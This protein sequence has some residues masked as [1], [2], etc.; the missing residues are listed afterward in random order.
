S[1]GNDMPVGGGDILLG[2]DYLKILEKLMEWRSEGKIVVI[3]SNTTD[4]CLHTNDLLKPSRAYWTAN[5]FT[6]YNYLRSW[7][8]SYEDITR[9]NPQY[10][11]LKSLLSSDGHVPGYRYDLFRPDGAKCTYQTDFFLCR[12]YCGDEV[13]I[14]V[15]GL[16]DWSLLEEAP[17]NR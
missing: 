16:A 10:D 3:T 4:I 17:A 13:R 2:A 15:S 12:D 5:Q 6:G 11:R 7:R 9:L 1:V 14:G 8:A